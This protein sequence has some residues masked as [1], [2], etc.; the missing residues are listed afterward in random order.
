MKRK[1]SITSFVFAAVVLLVE[2][3]GSPL[4]SAKE[5]PRRSDVQVVSQIGLPGS[6]IT[7]L[8]LRMNAVG[9]TFLYAVHSDHSISVLDVTNSAQ[10]KELDELHLTE[11][12]PQVHLGPV[13]P[14]AALA[15]AGCDAS[16]RPTVLNDTASLTIVKQFTHVDACTIDGGRSLVYIAEKGKLSILQ[17]D[18]PLTRE[19]EIWEQSYES[20]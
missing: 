12:S 9:Q 6:T 8:F 20:R 10:P 17:F 2:T 11:G 15:T 7:D 19:A 4:A 13:G 18:H 14:D 5:R 3:L 1:I 16:Q